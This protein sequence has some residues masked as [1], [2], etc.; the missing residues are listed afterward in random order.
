[1]ATRGELKNAPAIGFG[2]MAMA[3]RSAAA[4]HRFWV[5]D[6][7]VDVR[8]A[9]VE[10]VTGAHD[11]DDNER[12]DHGDAFAHKRWEPREVDHGEDDRRSYE[13]ARAPGQNVFADQAP[14]ALAGVLVGEHEKDRK[15]VVDDVATAIVLARLTSIGEMPARLSRI[16]ALVFCNQMTALALA[17]MALG[18]FAPS[19]E[20]AAASDKPSFTALAATCA[21][22]SDIRRLRSLQPGLVLSNLDL[23]PYIALATP[24]HAVAGPYHRIH[25]AIKRLVVA[26][27]APLDEAERH[28]REIG[29]DYVLLCAAP[30][31]VGGTGMAGEPAT[32][33]GHLR[34]GGGVPYLEEVDLGVMQ[35]PLKVWKVRPAA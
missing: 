5:R 13:D 25:P 33:S 9:T 7:R 11:V 19:A 18:L 12:D 32:L 15:S 31:E 4:R 23:G 14:L 16:A 22:K 1:L 27:R 6:N 21:Y 34:S 17:G 30:D 29:A 35:G 26:L 8:S 28:L 24:H 10:H 20:P 2:G 3:R